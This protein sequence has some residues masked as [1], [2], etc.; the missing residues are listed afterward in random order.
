M[1]RKCKESLRKLHPEELVGILSS[2]LAS[3]ERQV[4]VI[5]ALDECEGCSVLENYISRT[6]KGLLAKIFVTGRWGGISKEYF[7]EAVHIKRYLCIPYTDIKSYMNSRIAI[8]KLLSS[9][10]REIV[11]FRQKVEERIVELAHGK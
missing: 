11:R 2:L 1:L 3:F 6:L 7:G 10:R 5:D 8:N 4:L 9:G